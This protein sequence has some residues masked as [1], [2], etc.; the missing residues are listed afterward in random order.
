MLPDLDTAPPDRDRL[1]DELDVVRD[2]VL[3]GPN[4]WRREPVVTGDVLAGDLAGRPDLLDEALARLHAE[5]PGLRDTAA[6]APLND[7]DAWAHAVAALAIELQRQAGSDVGEWRVV[8]PG[9]EPE[10]R[11]FAIGYAEEGVGLASVRA[12][13]RLMRRALR[14]DRLAVDELLDDLRDRHRRD[15]LDAT[16]A[17]IVAE[18]RR[19]GVPVRR[20]P[21]ERVV[22]LGT[23]CRRRRIDGARTDRT[24]VIGTEIT[25]DRE[26]T[27]DMLANVGVPV[28]RDRRDAREAEGR[29]HLVLVVDGR[30][31]AVVDGKTGEDETRALHPDNAAVCA[32]AA[33][34]VGLDV[35]QLTLVADDLARPF[36]ETGALVVDVVVPPDLAPFAGVPQVPGAIVDALFPPG[37]PSRIPVVAVTGTNGKTTTT[38]LVAHLL[39]EAGHRV[40][41]TSTDGVYAGDAMVFAGDMTGP[42]AADMVLSNPR[43]DAAVLETARGGILR[44][45]LGYDACDVGVVLNVTADH[46]GLRGIHTVE[47][48]AGVKAVIVSAVRADGH[49]VLNADD[50]LVLAM[51]E[52]TEAHA[53]LF[54][55]GSATGEA[56]AAHL[57]AGG[58]AVTVE[59]VVAGSAAE[60]LVLHRGAERTVLAPLAEVPL[61][62]GGAARF[63]VQNAAAASAAAWALGIAP[64]TIRAGLARFVPSA[65]TTPGRMNVVRVHG[66]T[67]IVDYAHNPA[68]IRALLDY[69]GRVDAGR[70][71]AVLHTPGDRRDDDIREMGA[72]GVGLDSVVF[73]ESPEYRRGRRVGESGALLVEGFVAA[74]GDAARSVVVEGQEAAVDEVLRQ[75]Q[76]RDLV[77]FVADD[78][79][80]VIERLEASAARASSGDA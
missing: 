60:A 8:A 25:E 49:A 80:I 29:E 74:G 63:Q 40:G 9:D 53:V 38:R 3:A 41:F 18:A 28:P 69:A 46:L 72:L 68:A 58:M 57:R 21:G 32:F 4:R 78:A 55:L 16:T 73:M 6:G 64:E 26:R 10:S 19:R 24:S 23:G 51:R 65:A 59:R 37:T 43:L 44:A 79:S 71:L 20:T 2:R 35:A 52:R 70:R 75:L 27:W 11:A 30:V 34:V 54:S 56:V 47:Q 1:A 77:L 61:T 31:V 36:R 12:A 66:A 76:P 22:Q 45:G 33:D 5:L 48:L 13:A 39:R 15:A 50:P 62:E 14:D 7:A 67:I 42:M 17:A